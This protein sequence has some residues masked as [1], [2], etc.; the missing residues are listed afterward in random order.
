MAEA[1]L[2]MSL[3]D[4]IAQASKKRDKKLPR[5]RKPGGAAPQSGPRKGLI[6]NRQKVAPN[7]NGATPQPRPKQQPQPQQPQ[8]QAQR[9]GQQGSQRKNKG[10]GG[11]PNLGIRGGQVQKRVI[12]VPAKLLRSPFPAAAPP[13]KLAQPGR[14]P[15]PEGKWQH[16]LYED[17]YVPPRRAPPAAQA[18]VVSTKLIITNLHHQVSEDDLMELFSTCGTVKGR[19]INF[20]NSGRSLGSGWVVFETRA[21]AEAAH[22]EYNGVKLDGNA[23]KITLADGPS[24][25]SLTK[26]SSGISVQ[27]PGA[28]GGSVGG[29][30]SGNAGKPEGGVQR[31]AA[32]AIRETAVASRGGSGRHGGGRSNRLRSTVVG[33][34]Q[35]DRDLQDYMQE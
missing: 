4:L 16:D 25:P 31:L 3:D 21:E 15:A 19:A 17:A 29:S 20:D 7:S 11:A 22:K 18:A 34:S 23:M 32:A 5:Q 6:K 12:E 13:K 35:L 2:T 14:Q 26:L 28:P 10:R 9:Q 8:Q 24:G 1:K 30:R 27:K 33:R